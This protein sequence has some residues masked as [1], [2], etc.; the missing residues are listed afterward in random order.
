MRSEKILTDISSV[1]SFNSVLT[2]LRSLNKSLLSD[3]LEQFMVFNRAYQIITAGIMESAEA[4]YFN[5]PVFI[6]KFTA[7]FARYYFR[8]VKAAAQNS[9]DTPE[10]WALLA[11]TKRSVKTPHFIFLL[12]GAN[13]HINADL[14]LALKETMGKK[15]TEELLSDVLKVDKIL[16]KSGKKLLGEFNE[17]NAVIDTLKRRL[18]FLYYRPVM[19][20]ILTWRIRAWRNYHL[21][22][23]SPAHAENYTKH[24]IRTAHRLLRLSK[25]MNKVI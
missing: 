13:A 23:E 14:P 24:S 15:K 7:C 21:I 10:A 20:T 12:M 22:K 11:D 25:Y 6:E 1:D 9:N 4:G 2:T 5:S 19:Y 8:A 18:V 17:Q 3:S 16:M